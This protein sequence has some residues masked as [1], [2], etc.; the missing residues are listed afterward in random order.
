MTRRSI[1]WVTAEPPNGRLGEVGL[2]MRADG[3]DI[4]LLS[5]EN[6]HVFQSGAQISYPDGRT[7]RVTALKEE[8]V[9]QLESTMNGADRRR[10]LLRKAG[11]AAVVLLATS[12][13]G[14]VT[15]TLWQAGEARREA[16]NA[17]VQARRAVLVRDFLAHVLKSTEPASGGVPT[18][19]ELLDEGARRVRSNVLETDP[20]AAAD[21][22]MLTGRARME[23]DALDDALADL[24]Q[25]G[26]I[27]AASD[28]TAYAERA[29]VEAALSGVM[30][31]AGRTEAAIAHA[32][33]AVELGTLALAENDDAAPYLNAR[34][35]LGE[36]LYFSDRHASLAEFEAVV[37]ALP[38][39]GLGDTELHLVAFN[40]LIEQAHSTGRDDVGT[41]LAKLEEVFRLSRVVDGPD[42]GGYVHSLAN[43]VV[44]FLTAGQ[45]ERAGQLA[46]EAVEIADRIYAAPHSTRALAYCAAGGYLYYTGRN[47]E[48]LRYYSVSDGIYAQIPN[49]QQQIESCVR[50]SGHAHL[51]TGRL[52]VALANLGQ[53]WRILEQLDYRHT[54][55]GYD[56]CGLLA[57]AQ[58]RAGAVD[59]AGHT[60][61][62]CPQ[63]AEA[64]QAIMRMQAQAELLFA[65]GQAGEAA[66]LAAQ[67]R[68]RYPPEA[69]LTR[70]QWM[71]PWMLSL[72]LAR[73][74]G[75]AEAEAELAIALG[76]LGEVPPLA[77]CLASPVESTC[78]A[79]P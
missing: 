41:Y 67:I 58:L 32:E 52:D 74:A 57:T 54:K 26:T 55:Q 18:A 63:D 34:A 49:N 70:T 65:R 62:L 43:S 68:Q 69:D 29:A 64:P 6:P 15:A 25:A 1:L 9:R 61:S 35:Q 45:D 40:G 47:A 51:S 17:T 14:G 31:E 77:Q 59:Q 33:R 38:H 66:R 22:L 12:L 7:L 16:D 21:I 30:R 71:R 23:L 4:V 36:A 27:L 75:D 28:T 56:T 79:V 48:S 5:N 42:S 44:M 78:L 50:M 60:L 20:L 10:D 73:K 13:A 3:G 24:E 46:F 76:R 8:A 2:Q 19:L 11:V 37:E 53:A 72:L 39:Y